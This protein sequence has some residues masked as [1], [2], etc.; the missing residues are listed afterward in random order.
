MP[1][2][3]DSTAAVTEF[4]GSEASVE[5]SRDSA[6]A[7][8]D[9]LGSDVLAEHGGDSAAAVASFLE[10]PEED[11]AEDGADFGMSVAGVWGD[12]P[13]PEEKLA[14]EEEPPAP[15]EQAPRAVVVLGKFGAPVE[16]RH[17]MP[18]FDWA[19]N[20]LLPR[21]HAMCLQHLVFFGT[22]VTHT[23]ASIQCMGDDGLGPSALSDLGKTML[24]SNTTDFR[25]YL[26]E[27]V[28]CTKT[29]R[30]LIMFSA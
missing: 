6:V 4:L 20:P 11:R 24:A 19:A 29:S 3:S 7:L 27:T 12:A 1:E 28:P 23:Q 26:E 25:Q 2:L 14:Q 21:I 9:F 30:F 5:D 8:E 10:S 22:R 18:K 16:R 15:G 13:P 17:R